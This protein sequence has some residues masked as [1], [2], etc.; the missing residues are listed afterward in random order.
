MADLDQVELRV[1]RLVEGGLG[2]GFYERIPILVPGS[3]PGDHLRVALT[4]KQ[5]DY[6]RG[7]IRK[8]LEPGESRA[9]PPCPLYAECGG[10]DLQHVESSRQ[11]EMKVSA[12]LETLRRIGGIQ[13]VQHELLQGA[14]LAY[15][16]RAQLQVRGE[17]NELDVGFFGRGSND[18][19][20]TLRCPVLVPELEAWLPRILVALRAES[21]PPKRLDLLAGDDGT[22]SVAPVV[23]G[24]PHGAVV[25]RVGD[26]EYEVDARCFFQAHASLAARLVEVAVGELEGEAV[27][28]LHAGVGLFTLPLSRRYGKAFVAESDRVAVRYLRR[29]AKRHKAEGLEISPTTAEHAVETWSAGPDQDQFARAERW[30]LD[31][32]RSGLSRKLVA[33]LSRFRP[34]RVTYVSCQ[35]P[36][37][38]RDLS[39][40][41]WIYEVEQVTFLDLF[42]QTAHLEAVVQLRRRE[43]LK[44][45]KLEAPEA[46]SRS[47]SRSREV[48]GPRPGGP[49]RDS[50]RGG[51]RDA[52]TFGRGQGRDS[53]SGGRRPREAGPRDSRGPRRDGG[54]RD[55]ERPDRRRGPRGE[56][57]PM[58][59]RP[60]RR[61]SRPDG[62]GP[63]RRSGPLRQRDQDGGPRGGERPKVTRRPK[64]GGGW[65]GDTG[66]RPGGR[67]ADPRDADGRTPRRRRPDEPGKEPRRKPEAEEED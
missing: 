39:K 43:V 56:G 35:V 32:P 18:L 5:P 15:R 61:G 42:P 4:D 44:Q 16:G 34:E 24:L 13:N 51:R 66:D 30:L 50:D 8:I 6:A 26:F 53:E 12:A 20:P 29:N 25:R 22:L 49:G 36:T 48:S 1:D 3:A 54:F 45:R 17:G 21:S 10:C 23:E 7:E 63:R 64:L 47:R 28:E 59:R 62:D 41:D 60:D 14:G 37:L 65:G 46:S 55:R 67:G 52:Q 38:A 11:A 57:A 9:E 58:D 33:Q 2:L 19:V 31:P 40:L 27:V